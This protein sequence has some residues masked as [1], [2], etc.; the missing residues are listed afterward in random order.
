MSFETPA[1]VYVKLEILKKSKI[2]SNCKQE[3]NIE[4][5]LYRDLKIGAAISPTTYSS[6]PEVHS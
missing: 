3:L 5:M 4:A 6:N 1:N 2:N